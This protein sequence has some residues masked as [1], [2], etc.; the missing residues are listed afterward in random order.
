MTNDNTTSE[1]VEPG[2]EVFL[3][4]GFEDGVGWF[5]DVR[6]PD[7]HRDEALAFVEELI[8][9]GDRSMRLHREL[10]DRFTG[11]AGQGQP[12]GDR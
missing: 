10:Q 5:D 3:H 4:K 9:A 12:R 11:F 7:Q 6:I 8:R 2:D 1:T